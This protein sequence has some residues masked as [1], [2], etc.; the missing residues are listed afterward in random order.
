MAVLLNA[1]EK[2]GTVLVAVSRL[3]SAYERRSWDLAR[4]RVCKR[5]CIVQGVQSN[6]SHG[7][8]TNLGEECNISR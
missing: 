1:G 5:S 6:L 8:T 7:Y 2:D 3:M 4:V